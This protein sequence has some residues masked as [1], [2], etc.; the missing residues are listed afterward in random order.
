M[1]EM[2]VGLTIFEWDSCSQRRRERALD[3]DG[4]QVG[5]T[6]GGSNGVTLAASDNFKCLWSRGGADWGANADRRWQIDERLAV[7]GENRRPCS[8][9][10]LVAASWFYGSRERRRSQPA[11]YHK[12]KKMIVRRGISQ[13]DIIRNSRSV[14]CCRELFMSTERVRRRLVINS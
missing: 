7:K 1:I 4:R 9:P 10:R 8:S 13:K 14:D 11:A 3:F 6:T 12:G 5:A 2:S